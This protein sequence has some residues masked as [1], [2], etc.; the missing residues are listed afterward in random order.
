MD[1]SGHGVSA[2]RVPLNNDRA[3]GLEPL[4]V[5]FGQ[6]VFWYNGRELLIACFLTAHDGRV[7]TERRR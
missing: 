1:T 6:L 5:R 7:R 2:W 4:I 3:R